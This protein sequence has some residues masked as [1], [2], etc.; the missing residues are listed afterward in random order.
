METVVAVRGA[1]AHVQQRGI[2]VFVHERGAERQGAGDG[3]TATNELF[4]RKVIT[5]ELKNATKKMPRRSNC[6]TGSDALDRVLVGRLRAHGQ[7]RETVRRLPSG[8]EEGPSRPSCQT[9]KSG[10]SHHTGCSHVY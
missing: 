1:A 5:E 7:G 4:G 9:I 6:E 2:C 8:R 3:Q 10:S